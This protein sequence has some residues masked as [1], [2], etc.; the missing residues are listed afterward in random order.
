[1]SPRCAPPC[2]GSGCRMRWGSRRIW[3]SSCD[4]RASSGRNHR[5][6][7]GRPRTR[8]RLIDGSRA[9]PSAPWPGGCRRRRGDRSR[10]AMGRSRVAAPGLRRSA[11]HRPTPGV[12]A[13][14]HPK[15]G[16]CARKKP[17]AP[18]ASSTTSCICRRR[19]RCARWWPLRISAGRSNSSIRNSNRE[20]GLDHFEGRSYP[21][22]QHHVVL[23]AVAHAY[24]QRERMRRGA[25]GLTFPAVRAI[26]QEIFTALLFAQKPRYMQ[27][28]EQA[29]HKLQLRI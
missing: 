12:K 13:S 15:S 11:S 25:A 16:C 19:P 1:M 18:S 9:W 27:W 2:I 10:G 8:P 28:M 29:K 6:G 3:S 17:D 14:S 20:L 7:P 4:A 5:P 24:I 23:T 26:V 22:W 21:G